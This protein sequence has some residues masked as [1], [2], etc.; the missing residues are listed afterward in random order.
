M[1]ATPEEK[2]AKAAAR[3]QKELLHCKRKRKN[4]LFNRDSLP[5]LYR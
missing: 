2:A 5:H 4:R 3:D 1:M